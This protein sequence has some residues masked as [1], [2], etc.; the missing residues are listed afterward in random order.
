MRRLFT[1]S[2]LSLLGA[3]IAFSACGDENDPGYWVKK[4]DDAI[5][6]RQAV[7]QISRLYGTALSKNGGNRQAPAVRAIAD[8]TVGPLVSTYTGHAEDNPNRLLIIRALKEM[9]DPR[10][11][12]A[13]LAALEFTPDVSEESA[14]SAAEA[15]PYLTPPPVSAIPKIADAYGRITENRGLDNRMRIAFIKALGAIGDRSA[16][17]VLVRIMETESESQVYIINALAATTLGQFRDPTSVGPLVTALQKCRYD[18]NGLNSLDAAAASALVRIGRPALQPLIDS[19][20]MRNQEAQQAAQRCNQNVRQRQTEVGADAWRVELIRRNAYAIGSLGLIEGIEPLRALLT[21][22]DPVVR[23]SAATALATIGRS[24]Q[25]FD[26]ISPL[27]A[28]FSGEENSQARHQLIVAIRHLFDARAV[29]FLQRIADNSQEEP[30]ARQLAFEAIVYL[31]DQ[32]AI[33]I[34]DRLITN[35]RGRGDEA[36]MTDSFTQLRP[37]LQ[38]AAECQ[39]RVECWVQKLGDANPKVVRKAAHMLGRLGQGSAAAQQALLQH[40][41][42]QDEQARVDMLYAL[43]AI[44][45]QGSAAA[46]TRIDEIRRGE[47]GRAIQSHTDPL[48]LTIQARLQARAGGT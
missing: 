9:R 48:M 11:L 19:L 40:L 45:P 29:E 7:E 32:S 8:T 21:N 10:A 36:I 22:T 41:S 16:V 27:Y 47:E 25:I 43:D 24:P 5:Y 15:L 30:D 3:S 6:R 34:A 26:A 12:P 18:S 33:P 38:S 1:V 37:V 14:A 31:G 46:V 44:S 42:T 28:G 35:E 23:L 20:Q 39:A 13:F 4:L 17:P 2:V